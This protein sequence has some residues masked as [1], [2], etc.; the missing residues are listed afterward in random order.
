MGI[1]K[2]T[3]Q[4][5][6]RQAFGCT[7]P[8]RRQNTTGLWF[9]ANQKAEI[10]RSQFQCCA[11]ARPASEHMCRGRAAKAVRAGDLKHESRR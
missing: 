3:Q 10:V 6:L 4:G 11:A 5:A 2:L 1:D 7:E 9:E 8:G